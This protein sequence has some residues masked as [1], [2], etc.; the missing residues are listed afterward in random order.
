MARPEKQ[1]LEY[2]PLDINIESDDKVYLIHAKH[3]IVGFGLL[4]KLLIKIYRN[5]YYMKFGEREEII[6]ASQNNIDVIACKNIINDCINESFFDKNI[7]YNYKILT[8]RGIQKRYFKIVE[9]RKKVEYIEEIM[10]IDIDTSKY[11]NLVNVSINSINVDNNSTR[12]KNSEV[13][14]NIST[15]SKGKEIENKVKQTETEIKEKGTLSSEQKKAHST[16]GFDMPTDSGMEYLGNAKDTM[17]DTSLA[18][19]HSDGFVPVYKEE[20][21]RSG[22]VDHADDNGTD[23]NGRITRDGI[24]VIVNSIEGGS[25]SDGADHSPDYIQPDDK[26]LTVDYLGNGTGGEE[27]SPRRHKKSKNTTEQDFILPDWVPKQEWDNFVEMRKK[28]RRPMTEAAMKL[29]VRELEKLRQKGE[30]VVSVINQSILNA[31][32]SF[33]P[34]KNEQS[35]GFYGKRTS[36]HVRLDEKD[37]TGFK[38]W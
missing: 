19:G 24:P 15:Q 17:Q 16:L 20:I 25:H 36:G 21:A 2:F 32:Q 12:I 35:G 9:R 34:I 29:A 6:F 27:Q 28:I 38:S 11:E 26:D 5:G 7:Y 8:S 37:Y 13:N 30:D 14:V 31:W 18:V 3:G 33:Y 4:I 23:G 1:G 22:G 10:L